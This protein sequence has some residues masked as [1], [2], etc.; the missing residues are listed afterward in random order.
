MKINPDSVQT[1]GGLCAWVDTP[2]CT[3]MRTHI[4]IKTCPGMYT[5]AYTHIHKNMPRYVHTYLHIYTYLYTYTHA[6]MNMLANIKI[7]HTHTH[8]HKHTHTHTHTHTQTQ[9]ASRSMEGPDIGKKCKE[10]NS[11]D[12]GWPYSCAF[13]TNFALSYFIFIQKMCKDFNSGDTVSPY[14]CSC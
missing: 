6:L 8:T 2:V 14:S 12:T 9:G 1:P 3:H 13:V 5:H 10:F 11:G 4:Y 7:L